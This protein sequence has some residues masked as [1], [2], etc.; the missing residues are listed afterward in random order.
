MP[1]DLL[2]AVNRRLAPFAFRR[3]MQMRNARP[4]VSFSFDDVP[5]SAC[6][7]GAAIL[8]AAG[9]YGTY[10]VCGSLCDR[11]EDG[12][13]YLTSQDLVALNGRGHELGCH[14]FSHVHVPTLGSEAIR[15]EIY[16]N[17]RFIEQACGDVLLRNFSYPFGDVSPRSR[18]M[19]QSHYSS[20]RGITAGVNRGTID[21]GLLKAIS[22]YDRTYEQNLITRYLDFALRT[23]GW[24]IFYTHDVDDPPSL[25]GT[26]QSVF[27]RLVTKVAELNIPILTVRSALGEIGFRSAAP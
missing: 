18:A 2:G 26:S 14:T 5:R 3:T 19:A 17:A 15:T 16:R 9:G 10:Y 21:L 22:I 8:E 25:H 13:T 12:E 27:E 20:C 24:L 23:N 11:A 1:P 4:I 6:T 7:R